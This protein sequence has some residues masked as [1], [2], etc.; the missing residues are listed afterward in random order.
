M[1]DDR[2]ALQDMEI[3]PEQDQEP[4]GGSSGTNIL[5]TKQMLFKIFII[6][7]TTAGDTKAFG[8]GSIT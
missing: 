6:H 2:W 3:I 4:S 8:L 1:R 7:L 5:P